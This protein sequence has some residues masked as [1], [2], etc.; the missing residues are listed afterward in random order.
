MR[1]PGVVVWT[2]GVATDTRRGGG[3]T[4]FFPEAI[5]PELGSKRGAGGGCWVLFVIL[6][7]C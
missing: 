2:S 4:L 1:R 3:G 7:V 5:A 6:F